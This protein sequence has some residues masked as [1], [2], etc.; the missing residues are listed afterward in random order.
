MS[1]TAE[2]IQKN[3]NKF[4]G[5]LDN[6]KGERKEKL[7]AMYDDLEE[8]TMMSPASSFD[9]YH[10]AFPG[11]Y[12]DHVLRVMDCATN[13]YDLWANMGANMTGYTREELLF[14]AMHH[15]LGKLGFPGDGNE[16]YIPN[17]SDWHRKNL[18]KIYTPN[19]NNPF[20][21]VPDLTVWLLQH[22]DIKISWNELLGLKLTD[23]LYDESTKPYFISRTSDSKLKTNLGYVMHQADCMAARIEYENWK[24]SNTDVKPSTTVN[25]SYGKKARTQKLGNIVNRTP[26][27]N[28]DKIG[29]SKLFEDLFGDK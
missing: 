5:R 12:V 7:L 29:A 2:Q 24:S 19:P 23:G 6:F 11:G 17:E 22:Y 18:G 3:W 21:M 27:N 14:V 20:S 1:L 15:D 26:S 16:V 28:N 9:H 10:N 25:T 4:I 8:R 13:V